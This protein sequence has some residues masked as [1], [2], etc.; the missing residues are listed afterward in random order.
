MKRLVP[1]AVLLVALPAV[2]EAKSLE[3]PVW[4]SGA[5]LRAVPAY[6]GDR[7][8]IQLRP[9]VARALRARVARYPS[10]N[11]G[12]SGIDRVLSDLGA[13]LEPE[14][15]GETSPPPGSG[16]TDFTTFYLVDLPPRLDLLT[17]LRR[18][19]EVAEIAQ[20]SPIGIAPVAAVPNDSLWSDS[21]WFYQDSRMDI[22]APEAWDRTRG[23]T[24]IVVALIDTGLIPYHPDL[25][26]STPG[27][28]GKI[29][30]NRAEASGRPG[31]DDD[32]NGFVD[33]VWGW[34]FVS[35]PS[36]AGVTAGEDWQDQD[37]DPND[38]VGHGTG[39]AGLIGALTDNQHGI[40]GT[41]WKCPIMPLRVGWSLQERQT[42]VVDMSYIAQAVRYATR[43][44]AKVINISLSTT[45]LSEL[46]HAV[47]A[48]IAAGVTVVIAA[49][50]NGSPVALQPRP[51]LIYVTAT[52]RNDV[53]PP[54][55]N[56]GQ[57]VTLAA[58]GA[59]LATTLLTRT[60]TDSIGMRQP[61]YVP[62]ANGTSFAAPIV[63]GAVALLLSYQRQSGSQL[64]TP[65]GVRLTLMTACDDISAQNPTLG[66]GGGRP[67][68]YYGAG[69]LNIGRV[70]NA[71]GPR[72]AQIGIPCVGAPV[73]FVTMRGERRL[74][75]MT[76]TR[77]LLVLDPR[78]LET[79]GDYDL[80]GGP[81]GDLAAAD[82]GQGRGLGF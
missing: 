69:R 75:I 61:A 6:R 33:D 20:A 76:S 39:V 78:T 2:A 31:V 38:F 47:D 53:V 63:S 82:L 18:F 7:I 36:G 77:R 21:W 62:D 79:L 34:D 16:A 43:M 1:F 14:F 27:S 8:S 29:W 80:G 10:G 12:V 71:G 25:G 41:A 58:A 66:G 49:G 55:A 60:G 45:A 52:D 32:A 65:E 11:V 51:G 13:R 54:W 35:L 73:D 37:N 28:R 50:N 23:D 3:W 40:A 48:A 9:E 5:P 44:G 22:H 30:T 19:G 59:A 68:P 67:S 46:D 70:M 42:G 17:A 15:R 26:G 57:Y 81:S 72:A 74:A 24:S 64:L 56:V 4:R